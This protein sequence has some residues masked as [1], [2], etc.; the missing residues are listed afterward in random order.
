SDRH[1]QMLRE[2]FP[3]SPHLEEA[4]ILGS[5]VKLMSYQG[6]EYEGKTLN[7]A[8][9]L[10]ESTLRLYPES[11][12]KE[13]L[14]KELGLIE[15]AGALR[16][17]KQ[18]EF[19]QGKGDKRAAAIYCN[20]VIARYPKSPLADKARQRL[21]ELGPEYASGSA[22]MQPT[23]PKK[24]TLA[25]Q[26][27]KPFASRANGSQNR[28]NSGRSSARQRNSADSDPQANLKR[29]LRGLR[30]SEIDSDDEQKTTD[31]L[32]PET[33]QTESPKKK[34]WLPWPR[35]RTLPDEASDDAQEIESA[36]RQPQTEL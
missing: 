28:M 30:D 5:H 19:W 18:V 17:W 24:P 32:E 11:S 31:D 1:F 25:Q 4:F 13:R 29:H 33:N 26:L 2:T 7:E 14:S 6:A 36:P 16:V 27:A 3:N 35:P 10:K 21:E 22:L 15:E 9:M 20:Q 8:R 12:D 23:D 34:S